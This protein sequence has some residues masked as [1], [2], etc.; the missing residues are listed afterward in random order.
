VT[1]VVVELTDGATH[2]ADSSAMAFRLCAAQCFREAIARAQPTLLEPWM[3]LTIS[4]P[5]ESVGA[6]I[7][8]VERRRGRVDNI[9]VG[10]SAHGVIACAPLTELFGFAN[11]LRTVSSGRATH[12]LELAEYA[13][14]K[15]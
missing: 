14:V 6:V 8:E 11:A 7:G 10:Q 9:E 4:T 1:D 5:R 3:R 2:P 12:H 13:R 15:R